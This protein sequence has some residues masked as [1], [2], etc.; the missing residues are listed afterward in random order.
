MVGRLMDSLLLAS[1]LLPKAA[2]DGTS[3]GVLYG[4]NAV[5]ACWDMVCGEATSSLAAIVDG[6]QLGHA[7]TARGLRLTAAS[8]TTARV[9]SQLHDTGLSR[10]PP[11]GDGPGRPVAVRL[12]PRIPFAMLLADDRYCIV[13]PRGNAEDLALFITDKEPIHRLQVCFD[14]LWS[15]G[16]ADEVKLSAD[17]LDRLILIMLAEGATDQMIGRR[18][19][20][21]TRT[22]QRRVQSMM[23]R[24]DART[25]FQAGLNAARRNWIPPSR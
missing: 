2:P 13:I 11:S 4:R 18:L 10:L 15:M 23:L 1:G 8:G 19:H 14:T 22:V 21:S 3:T 9:I 25:R 16:V 24:L 5:L 6:R 12:I 17:D 7:A 20:L